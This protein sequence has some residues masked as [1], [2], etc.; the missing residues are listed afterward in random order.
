VCYEKD[1]HKADVNIFQQFQVPN[2]K[3]YTKTGQ[4]M[5]A[6]SVL[7]SVLDIQTHKS[8]GVTCER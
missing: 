6:F 5:M 4:R 1:K 8:E 7:F 3:F 2:G